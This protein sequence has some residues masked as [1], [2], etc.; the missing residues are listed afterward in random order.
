[1]EK[2]ILIR[3]GLKR[4][5]GTL[6]GI[7]L[8][9]ALIAAVTG[10]VLTL[11]AN[12]AAHEEAGLTQAGFG[13][14]TAWISGGADTESLAAEITALDEIDRVETQRLVFTNYTALE[15]ESDSEGQLI[16]YE[17]ER[18]R[19]RFFTDDL[20]GYQPAPESIRPGEVYVSP[21]LV[22]MFGL[23]IGDEITFPIARS[24]RDMVLKVA[25]FFEAPVMGSSM[26]GMKGFLVCESDYQAAL[27]TIASSGIDALA[28][29]GSMLHIFPW[30][31]LPTAQLNAILNEHTGLANFVEFTHSREAISG[32]MLVLQNAFSAL[33]LAF[34]AVLLMAVLAVAGH[35][36]SANIRA[37][38]KNMGILKTV[39]L[40]TTDLRL[41]LLAQ[42]GAAVLAGSALG[43]ILTAPI[44]SAVSSATVTTTGLKIPA[45]LPV[46]WLAVSFGGILLLLGGFIYWRAGKIGKVSPMRAIRGE[47]ETSDSSGKPA[48]Q[49]TEKTLPLR[50]ALRQLLT[51]RKMYLGAL[52]VAALLSFF[53]AMIG[54]M[55]AW[56]G[57]DGKG[58]MDAFNPADHDL[59]VQMFGESTIDSAKDI[60]QQ[61]SGITDTYLLAMPSVSVNGVDYTANAISEPER[62]H[63]LEGRACTGGNEIV[64][65]EFV[66]SDLGVDIGDMVTV[67]G[68]LAGGEY[69]VSGIYSCAN[70]MGANVGL[71]QAGYLKIGR[72]DPRIWCWHYFLSDP[73]QKA[74]ITQA[75]EERFGGD[76]HVH[77]NTWPGL[78]GI[79]AA[80][81]A[82]VAAMYITTAVFILVVTVLTGGRVLSAEQRDIAIYKAIGFA[83]SVQR[84]A[85]ALRFG[86]TALIG[87]LAGTVLSA[88]LSDRLVSAVMKLAGINNF[89]SG[90]SFGGTLLPVLAVTLLFAGFA[91]LAAGKIKRVAITSLINE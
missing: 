26:I 68:D 40:T 15:Q 10:T 6:C 4:H 71:S 53:A 76:V 75:L 88:A 44:S 58:M 39:G 83:D 49:I 27:D 8:L 70:D 43:L 28:R 61:Y 78:F 65:T 3:A 41:V 47:M 37:E 42:Y 1:M 91:W 14:L 19:Y 11:W 24:G 55:D 60:V 52:A 48:V 9:I 30:D 12:A 86:V 29:Q 77:E 13:E 84:L 80:M 16:L 73:S 21:S 36:I 51:G 38:Y 54:R 66:A 7:F 32:F 50:L 23:G 46:S 20:S 67:R 22:S 45:V 59:G 64:L 35:S 72:D 82:L 56:L 74:A 2:Q 79:I 33:F 69:T 18:E 89:A 62:F 90:V 63:I 85:F 34:A 31:D 81:R 87:S 5:Q 57:P 17:P 25:G